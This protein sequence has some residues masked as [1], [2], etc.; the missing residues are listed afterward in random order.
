MIPLEDHPDAMFA[1]RLT[2]LD[3]S[4][5]EVGDNHH[6]NWIDAKAE[7]ERMWER[8]SREFECRLE[9]VAFTPASW[10]TVEYAGFLIEPWGRHLGTTGA[11]SRTVDAKHREGP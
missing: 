2:A 8:Y 4:I 5:C 3:G 11:Y 10:P 1:V 6:A 9:V 7:A